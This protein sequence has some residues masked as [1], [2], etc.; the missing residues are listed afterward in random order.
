MTRHSAG[1]LR[2][3]QARRRRR[4]LIFTLA[5][6][7]LLMP[8]AAETQPPSGKTA[9]IGYLSSFSGP[10]DLD[11]AFRQGLRDL[12]YIEGQNIAIEYR[13][14]DFKPDRASTL[15]RRHLA[16]ASAPC[17]VVPGP[18]RPSSRHFLRQNAGGGESRFG[19]GPQR[20]LVQDEWLEGP[21]DARH[22]SG[23]LRTIFTNRRRLG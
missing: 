10:S 7:L 22:R 18:H 23:K 19:W 17:A 9:R 2:A 6:G 5:C 16:G 8:L 14:A 4:A 12:G 15:G 13:W 11:E 21:A 20:L 1:L 3:T